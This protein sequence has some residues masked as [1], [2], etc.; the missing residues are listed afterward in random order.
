MLLV[1]QDAVVDFMGIDPGDGV[2]NDHVVHVGSGFEDDFARRQVIR[3]RF[4]LDWLS[5]GPALSTAGRCGSAGFSWLN[6]GLCFNDGGL[7]FGHFGLGVPQ[8]IDFYVELHQICR[9]HH[10][11]VA[12]FALGVEDANEGDGGGQR[13]DDVVQGMECCGRCVSCF[14]SG[15]LRLFVLGLTRMLG[16]ECGG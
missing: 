6:R 9:T 12:R 4:E 7:D 1:I 14:G 15:V 11:D 8:G 5:A 2:V 16:A 13:G 3:W 10:A